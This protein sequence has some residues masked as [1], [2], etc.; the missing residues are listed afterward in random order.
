M[1]PKNK[2]LQFLSRYLI[3]IGVDAIITDITKQSN[4][5]IYINALCLV[6]IAEIVFYINKKKKQTKEFDSFKKEKSF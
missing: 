4:S 6:V 2:I 3:I 1:F 5:Q